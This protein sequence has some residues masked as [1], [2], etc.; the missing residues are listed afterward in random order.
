MKFSCKV[1]GLL[2]GIAPAIGVSTHSVVKDFRSAGKISL[3]SNQSEI[4]VSVFNGKVAVYSVVSDLTSGDLGYSC[5]SVGLV[6]VSSIDL[7]N[8][9][10]SFKKDDEIQVSVSNA[11]SG[12]E[13]VIS[14]KSDSEEY[15]TLPCASEDI[16]MP[17]S[18]KKFEKEVTIDR[19]VYNYG[20]NKIFWSIGYEDNMPQYL[21]WALRLNKDEVRFVAGTGGRFSVLTIDGENFVKSNSDESFTILFPKDHTESVKKIFNSIDDEKLEIKVNSKKS[22]NYQIAIKTKSHDIL[23]V[24]LDSDIDYPDENKFLSTS[25]ANR[26]VTN[27][28]EWGYVGKGIIATYS[29]EL[30]KEHRQSKA[31]VEVSKDASSLIVKSN[32]VMKAHRK[33]PVLGSVL[34]DDAIKFV[35]NSAF[36]KEL[37]EHGP[38][39]NNIQIEIPTEPKMPVVV[40][41]HALDD[42]K[43]SSM[44]SSKNES[45]GLNE[46]FAIFFARLS[47]DN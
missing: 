29:V 10:S 40:R 46:K 34:E 6:T 1:S 2:S 18:A 30:K 5:S 39:Q 13:L 11:N 44:L 23:F 26:F 16:E 25:I 32:S 14:K 45:S 38:D 21:H 33:V 35:C 3:E 27:I 17:K 31:S 37:A 9:L 22:S 28:S 20:V 7:Q 42:V 36:L 24:N 43:D 19:S 47:Q 4:V 15:Q 12:K 8:V 41:Y